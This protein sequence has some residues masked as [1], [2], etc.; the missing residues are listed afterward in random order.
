M[1]SQSSKIKKF[2]FLEHLVTVESEDENQDVEQNK[3][4]DEITNSAQSG[5]DYET[6][7]WG[8]FLHIK[9]KVLSGFHEI[10]HAKLQF[11]FAC[12]LKNDSFRIFLNI[13]VLKITQHSNITIK[14]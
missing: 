3:E 11:Y 1:K 5:D 8:K 2:D 10:S 14:Y 4:E 9:E 7:E 12:V 6:E 13:I